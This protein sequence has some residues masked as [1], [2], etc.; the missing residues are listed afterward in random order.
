MR[1]L[2]LKAILFVSAGGFALYMIGEL[3]LFLPVFTLI[4]GLYI[5]IKE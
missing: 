4:A 3:P 5:F 2:E 1:I